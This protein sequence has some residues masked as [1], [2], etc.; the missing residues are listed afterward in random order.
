MEISIERKKHFK[1]ILLLAAKIGIGSSAAI[2]I[3]QLLNLQHATSAGT[4]TLLTLM[5][6]KWDTVKLSGFRLITF[7]VTALTAWAAFAHIDSKII[8]YGVFIFIVVFLAEVSG[9]KATISVNSVIG[10]HLLISMDFSLHSLENELMLILIGIAIALVLN[11]FHDNHHRRQDLVTDMRYTERQLQVILTELA[12]Y[13]SGDALQRDVWQDL[14]QLEKEIQG[15]QKEAY[16]YQ[17]NTF[18]S[19]PGYYI[20]YFE[21]RQ[22]QCQMLHNLH[23]EMRKIRTL[24]KQSQMV[25][26]YLRYLTAY[27]IERNEPALQIQKLEEIFDCMRKEELPLSMEEFENRA[28]LYH[29]LM[30][31]EEFLL[32]KKRFIKGLNERQRKEY[33]N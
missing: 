32:F 31:I 25:A 20:D 28:L 30:D 29:I 19:H 23:G 12:A 27:V 21:M 7:A 13:L 22:N 17:E 5:T 2:W 18:H 15:F 10:A 24:P 4:I 33:W 11:L 26:E 14:R 1:K 8:S 16:E 3:A 9:L 6:T